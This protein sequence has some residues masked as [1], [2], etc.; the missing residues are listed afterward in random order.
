MFNDAGRFKRRKN[1]DYKELIEKLEENRHM[2]KKAQEE[3]RCI[4]DAL[5]RDLIERGYIDI[6]SINYRRLYQQFGR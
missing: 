2:I 6:L 5:K 3:N 4:E 1:M